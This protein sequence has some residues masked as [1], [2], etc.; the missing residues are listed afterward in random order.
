M[1]PPHVLGPIGAYLAGDDFSWCTGEI[2]FSNGSEVAVIAPPRLLEVVRSRDVPSLA[3]ALQ[4]LVP[5]AFATAEAGQATNG[6]TN[7]RFG[8]I[9]EPQAGSPLSLATAANCLLVTDDEG[10]AS[11]LAGAFEPR[12]LS[13][14]LVLAGHAGE[15]DPS[16]P[17]A[18]ADSFRGAAEKLTAS[19]RPL[20]AVVV[21]LGH[22]QNPGSGSPGTDGWQQVLDEH[23]G[24]ADQILADTTWVRAASDYSVSSDR[25]VR[26]VTVV[27]AT[28]PAGRTR[29][30]AA[31]QLARG[32]L[33][34]TSGRVAA[35]AVS[36]ETSGPSERRN[37][38]ELVAH[39]LCTDGTEALAG[40]ELAAGPGWLGLR[41]HPNPTGSVSFGGPQ[42]PDWLDGVMRQMIQPTRDPTSPMIEQL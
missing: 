32:S 6:A 23:G 15:L 3:W 10:W 22:V 33:Q 38:A 13:C 39:L 7:P 16:S 18:I 20:D 30:Q 21:A 5:L 29:A 11:V 19:A 12:G 14:T 41:S 42:V 35:F 40:A 36:V 2:I 27:D 34:A 37:L 25:P 31:V 8:P 4:S 26:V 17:R 9:F 1:P 28:S 24:I